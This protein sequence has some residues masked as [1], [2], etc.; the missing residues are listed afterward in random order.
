MLVPLRYL[1]MTSA[2]PQRAQQNITS[3]QAEETPTKCK[4]SFILRFPM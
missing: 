2:I 1:D 4:N 3:P